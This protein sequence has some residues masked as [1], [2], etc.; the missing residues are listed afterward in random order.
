MVV[1]VDLVDVSEVLG[2]IER[3]GDRYV[4]RIFTDDEIDY[5]RSRAPSLA[6][7]GMRFAARFAAKEATIK[8]LRTEAR[9]DFRSIEVRR[10]KVGWCDLVLH[11]AAREMAEQAGIEGLSL[12]MSHEPR[13]ATAVVVARRSRLGSWRASLRRSL[14]SWR[15]GR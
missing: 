6:D 14:T 13:Y 3:F 4:R 7:Q 12:S 8:V 10:S 2:S 11:G 1:G 15:R 9:P 5:C